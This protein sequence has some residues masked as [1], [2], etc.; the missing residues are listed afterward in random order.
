LPLDDG[1]RLRLQVL[2]RERNHIIQTLRDW[3][4]TPVPCGVLPRIDPMGVIPAAIW[5]IDLPRQQQP[6][7]D[8]RTIRGELAEREKTSAE[9]EGIKKYLGLK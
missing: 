1:K 8:D 6:I 2:E 4:W 3:G 5:E 7:V 9:V